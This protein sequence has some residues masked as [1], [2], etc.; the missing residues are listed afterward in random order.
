MLPAVRP[1]RI[2]RLQL[3]SRAGQTR[4]KR[5]RESGLAKDKT[6]LDLARE[7]YCLTIAVYILAKR[8]LRTVPPNR[9]TNLLLEGFSFHRLAAVRQR[10]ATSSDARRR[11]NII[12][13]A[14]AVYIDTPAK[15]VMGSYLHRL[16]AGR[17]RPNRP[18][19]FASSRSQIAVQLNDLVIV[20][21][22]CMQLTRRT[23]EWLVNFEIN[24][25]N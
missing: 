9:Q 14:F 24:P 7:F 6:A 4:R 13:V 23:A 17:L 1:F 19:C 12:T 8:C 16:T 20:A 5:D 2:S 15:I 21:V 3:Q 11:T 10:R 18:S 22:I 25:R